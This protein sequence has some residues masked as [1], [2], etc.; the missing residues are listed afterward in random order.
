M[1]DNLDAAQLS[2]LIELAWADD[3]SFDAIK[4]QTGL[5]EETVIRHMRRALKPASFRLWRKRITGRKTKHR[6]G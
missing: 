6:R 4:A 2:E 3:V 1:S 5:D